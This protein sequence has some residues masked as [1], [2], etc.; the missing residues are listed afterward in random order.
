MLALLK[1]PFRQ[2]NL[3]IAAILVLALLIG[4]AM[5][6]YAGMM[7]DQIAKL[8]ALPAMLLFAILLLYD[9]KLT[10]T[11]IILVR[12]G[13]DNILELTRFS[14]GGYQIGVGGLINAAVI[15][16]SI[17]LML[18]R[19]KTLSKNVVVVW[20]VFL[21]LSLYGILVSPAKPEALRSWLALLSYFS[22]FSSAFHFINNKEDFRFCVKLALFSSALPVLYSFIDI[23]LNHGQGGEEGFR[24]R[25]TFSHPNVLAFYLTLIIPMT[26]YILKSM[27]VGKNGL[28][29]LFLGCYL[30]LLLGLLIL[31]KT[32]SAWIACVITFALY[33]VFFERRYLVYMVVLGVVALFIPGVA[34]RLSDLGSGNEVVT[35]GKLNS[36]A[37]R[38]YIWESAWHWAGPSHYLQG[39]GLQSFK[40]LSIVF[41]PSAGKLKWGAHSVY[42]QLLFE[43]GLLGVGIFLYL[44]VQVLREFR[45]LFSFD[46]LAGFFLVLVVLNFLICAFSDNMLDYLSF[47]W[48]LW[49]ILG[50]GC[51]FVQTHAAPVRA[52]A[53][54]FAA[55]G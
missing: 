6:I 17:M 43:M 4:A 2:S 22:I 40:E 8:A 52:Q 45:K 10:L 3:I 19:P 27:P 38:V 25:S 41:F 39:Y 48:Y 26:F 21:L 20:S 24:L 51:A 46:R 11:L 44:Y 36:F 34:D 30:F 50:A 29:R 31:T 1:N 28:T 13:G 33:G 32:R 37:W 53:A 12:A 23:A 14:L 47:N 7:D 35:Y 18:E 5:P 55:Q 9:R 49:F 54:P 16:I 42:V 15:L